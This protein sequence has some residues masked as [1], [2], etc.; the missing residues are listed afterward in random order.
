MHQFLQA[1]D[2]SARTSSKL[3]LITMGTMFELAFLN[4][5]HVDIH[6]SYSKQEQRRLSD[7]IKYWDSLCKSSDQPHNE[8]YTL[9]PA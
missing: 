9:F 3:L 7:N 1:H 8:H 4:C 2:D 5:P 6:D